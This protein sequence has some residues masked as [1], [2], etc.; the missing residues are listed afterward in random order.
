MAEFNT[1]NVTNKVNISCACECNTELGQISKFGNTL[2]YSSC[3]QGGVWSDCGLSPFP[4]CGNESGMAG[5]KDNFV[6]WGFGNTY[7]ATRS[8][9]WNGTSWSSCTS[10]GVC[11][12]GASKGGA[13]TQNA[14][15]NAHGRIS[16]SC[17]NCVK[18]YNGSSWSAGTNRPTGQ[19][20]PAYHNGMLVGTQN[21]AMAH[22]GSTT[23]L[24]TCTEEWNG[25]SW[26][27]GGTNPIVASRGSATGTQNATIK[28]GGN[29]AV[30][31]HSEYNG[32]AWSTGDS[33]AF[34]TCYNT[35]QGGANSAISAMGGP[36]G[37]PFACICSTQTYNGSTW[38][39]GP[40]G[41]YAAIETASPSNAATASSSSG[42]VYGAN[43]FACYR[44][45]QQ[46]SYFEGKFQRTIT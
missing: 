29:P 10:Y 43:L 13:G 2:Q 33:L 25:S 17:Y 7:S 41:L 35:V 9:E 34:Q 3:F 46:L 11:M 42:V 15:M 30:T 36:G 31:T 45:H 6:V 37:S 12:C 24:P 40:N 27:I 14:A 18:N 16:P 22:G 21:S 5:D 44:C 32:S 8:F 38:S 19:F 26:S 20:D 39:T 4:Y 23:P 28:L 1:L